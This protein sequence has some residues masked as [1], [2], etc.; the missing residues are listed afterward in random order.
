MTFNLIKNAWIPARRLS[1]RRVWVRPGEVTDSFTDDPLLGL[2]FPRPDWNAAVSEWLIGLVFTAL[3]PD[4]DVDWA[5]RFVTPPPPDVLSAALAPL[6]FAFDLDGDGPR[7]FQDFDLLAGVEPKSL[8]GLFIDA[9]GENTL[10]NN[11]DLFIKRGGGDVLCLSYAA[12]ALITL[13]TYAPA[14]GAGH[15]TSMR[16]GGPL[17][18]L[19][20]P[21][22]KNVAGDEVTTLWDRLWANTPDQ[23][24]DPSD[25]TPDDPPS[26]PDWPLVF[27]WL[28][29]TRTSKNNEVTAPDQTTR[30]L[31][32]F[33]CPRRLRLIFQPT[34]TQ[35]CSLG[36]PVGDIL[37]VGYRTQNYGANYLGWIHPLSPYRPDKKSGPLPVH[38]QAGASDYGDWLAWWGFDGEPA[39]GVARWNDRRFQLGSALASDG[40][41]AFGFDMDNAKARQWL[42]ARLPWAPVYGDDAKSLKDAIRQLID[43]ADKT[44]QALLYAIKLAVW[45]QRDGKSYRLPET[46]PR[47]AASEDVKQFWRETETAFREQVKMLIERP[48]EHLDDRM[49]WLETLFTHGFRQFDGAVDLDGLTDAD[50]RRLIY[51]RGRLS[52]ALKPWGD[53]AKALGI[54]KANPTKRGKAA[55]QEKEST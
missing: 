38:P 45:G 30:R 18:T 13:Q 19:V 32:F 17:T 10:K 28:A 2:D 49:Q 50:P 36:G 16:G 41:E 33:A 25:P 55:V 52:G 34:D 26:H 23:G 35:V 22:R 21:R 1:G 27:P 48:A 31:A 14:G 40:V 8:N 5:S 37:A 24:W 39:Y 51:A 15:R 11:A 53:V 29:A 43:G 9:P 20:A 44:A 3:P 6:A 7:A 42:E 54:D 4:G 46:L 47:D 12:A